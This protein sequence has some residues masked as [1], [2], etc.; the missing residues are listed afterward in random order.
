[1]KKGIKLLIFILLICGFLFANTSPLPQYSNHSNPS[2]EFRPQ[3]NAA[4][5]AIFTSDNRYDNHFVRYCPADISTVTSIS[6]V[7]L[8]L[9][10]HSDNDIAC[11]N[12][13]PKSLFC[14]NCLLQ[15]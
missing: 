13:Q 8:K 1:M 7:F 12:P 14:Q 2:Y 10:G 3:S 6:K 11:N 4:Q 5:P 15:I 9:L